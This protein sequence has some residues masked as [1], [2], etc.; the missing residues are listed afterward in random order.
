LWIAR[1]YHPEEVFKYGMTDDEWMDML[2]DQIVLILTNEP[3]DIYA[4]AT[5]IPDD[6]MPDYDRLWTPERVDR[7]LDVLQKN[8]IA[9]EISARYKIPNE[10]IIKAAKARGIMFTFGTNNVDADFGRL[11]Y[12]L[13]MAEKCGLEPSDIWF[14]TMSIRNTRKVV[15]YNNF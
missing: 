8:S 15:N 2:V 5:Y 4:N 9:L 10:R 14:P 6:M 1:I 13:Q 11:E 7:V 3:V 12:S